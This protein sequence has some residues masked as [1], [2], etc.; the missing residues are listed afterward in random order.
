MLGGLL[1]IISLSLPLFPPKQ[2]RNKRV[3]S[4]GKNEAFLKIKLK[5]H[6][7][8]LPTVAHKESFLNLMIMGKTGKF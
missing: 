2:N 8:K 7:V 3:Y 5:Y 6:V 1:Q 4:K